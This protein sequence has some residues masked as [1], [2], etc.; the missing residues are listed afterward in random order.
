[1]T[2]SE[3]GVSLTGFYGSSTRS[4]VCRGSSSSEADSEQGLPWMELEQGAAL[5]RAHPH[6]SAAIIFDI[7]IG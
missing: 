5:Q 4:E 1:M 6:I 3:P 2:C 7:A